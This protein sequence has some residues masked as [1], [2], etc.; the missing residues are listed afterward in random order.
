ML[1]RV[2]LIA[3]SVVLLTCGACVGLGT[4]LWERSAISTAGKVD[5]IHPLPIPPLAKSTVD[6]SGTRVFDLRAE[7]GTHDFGTGPVATWGFN[8]AYLG[9]TLRAS[10]GERVQV[11]VHNALD[12]ATTVHWHGMHL[13]AKM[14]GG[15][16]QMIPSGA[17]WSPTWRIDQPVATL[18]YHPH[19]HG[20]T[21]AHV[22]RGLAGMFILDDPA[23]E[24]P[25]PKR[26]GV[27][28]IPVIVQDK[29]FGDGRLREDI[30]LGDVGLLGDTIVVNGSVAP[31]LDV[32]SE[33]VRLRLLNASNARAYNFEFVD[34]RT[35]ALVGTDG[36]LL[37]APHETRSIMLVPGERAEIV[38]TMRPGEQVVLRSTP[39]Q[40]GMNVILE[41]LSGG[42]DTFDILELRAAAKLEPSPPVPSRLADVPRLDPRDAVET[43]SFR[44]AEHAINGQGMRMDRIDAAVVKDATEIWRVTNDD[45]ML[46]SFHVHDVQFQVLRIGDRPPPPELAGW[47][48]TIYVRPGVRYEIIMTFAD[49]ADP[50]S[51]YMFHCHTL[52]HEDGGMMGQFVVLEPGQQPGRM[53]HAGHR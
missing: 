3:T 6:S 15:P 27:D 29:L 32:G 9:P 13:P 28:D 48:D 44:L 23:A 5:F 47:K 35:F 30:A 16:H 49:Y 39:Q 20:T 41:R 7:K 24:V 42:R 37:A 46:H 2:L 50:E 8:G 10:R 21:A 22:Y 43:R 52:L 53:H 34:G 51:P 17:T 26:Y 14:D 19:P 36:G 4:W 45:G 1:R 31:Y 12:E 33:Q 38:V 40:L 18:W 25:L 11:N